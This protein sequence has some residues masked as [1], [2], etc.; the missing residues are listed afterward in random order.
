MSM[1][2]RIQKQKLLQKLIIFLT[3]KQIETY[4]ENFYNLDKTVKEHGWNSEMGAT[5]FS[6][7]KSFTFDSNENFSKFV[8]EAITEKHSNHIH[9][10]M[11]SSINNQI[12][13]INVYSDDHSEYINCLEICLDLDQAY[14]DE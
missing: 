8:L 13:D 11:T 3:G 7:S 2:F 14:L 10:D 1:E 4:V 5:L 6:F 9:L 12:V